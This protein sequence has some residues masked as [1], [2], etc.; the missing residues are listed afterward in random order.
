[1]AKKR[2]WL[3]VEGN[4]EDCQ[5]FAIDGTEN[6]WSVSDSADSDSVWAWEVWVLMSMVFHWT[7]KSCTLDFNSGILVTCRSMQS[8]GT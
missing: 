7:I 6:K 4:V 3:T 8:D 1:M 2:E 5:C